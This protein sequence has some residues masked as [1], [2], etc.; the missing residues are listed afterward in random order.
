V[1]SGFGH[2]FGVL[3]PWWDQLFGTALF[4]QHDQAY[5]AT[6]VL[7]QNDYGRGFWEQQWLGL[8]RMV[9]G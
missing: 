5:E 7:D 1:N 6:G 2:N 3:L 8:K 9:R 4:Q